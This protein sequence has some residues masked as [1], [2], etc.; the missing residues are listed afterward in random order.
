MCHFTRC[1]LALQILMGCN[2]FVHPFLKLKMHKVWVPQIIRYFFHSFD[3]RQIVYCLLE[4]CLKKVELLCASGL[5]RD[6]K[7]TRQSTTSF[8]YFLTDM[9]SR[10]VRRA[11][12]II[13]IHNLYSAKCSHSAF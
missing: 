13:I 9:F 2:L 8:Q 6:N 12:M 1:L 4:L 5:G 3:N 7:G 10:A 11:M